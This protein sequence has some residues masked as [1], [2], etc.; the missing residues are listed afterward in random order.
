MRPVPGQG[1]ICFKCGKS[2]RASE[3]SFQVH[4]T[5]VARRGIVAW[6]ARET[7]IASSSGNV[8]VLLLLD[9]LQLPVPEVRLL[10]LVLLVAHFR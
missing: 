8:Q 3:C 9:P 5:L 10:Q 7:Q 6:F 1:L 4:A 2:H